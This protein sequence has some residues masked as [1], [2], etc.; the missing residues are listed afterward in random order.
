MIDI[1]TDIP[2]E[3]RKRFACQ[4]ARTVLEKLKTSKK[5]RAV[6]RIIKKEIK[7]HM[8]EKEE[9]IRTQK[10]KKKN[11]YKCVE[12]LSY[13][14][15]YEKESDKKRVKACGKNIHGKQKGSFAR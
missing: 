11:D 4:S 5:G 6:K 1:R 13:K 2:Q 9:E 3:S 10:K 14:L 15:S 8:R 7:V 12:A